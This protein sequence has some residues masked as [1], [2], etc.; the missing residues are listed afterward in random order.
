M[1]PAILVSVTLKPSRSLGSAKHSDR[2][3]TCGR[4]RWS[5][6]GRRPSG[7]QNHGSASQTRNRLFVKGVQGYEKVMIVDD[8]AFMRKVV[9]DLL[10]QL[11]DIEVTVAARNGKTS[12]GLFD[13][14][15]DR[16]GGN[17]CGDASD[18]RIERPCGR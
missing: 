15:S 18:E 7:F 14:R 5:N 11:P 2:G 13:Q 17:G 16:F 6:H 10:N 12:I 9:T 3:Q 1:L 8:S 4:Q